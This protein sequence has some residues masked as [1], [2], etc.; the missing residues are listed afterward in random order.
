VAAELGVSRTPVREAPACLRDDRLVEV[1]PQS[2]TFVTR[3]DPQTVSDA[4]VIREA[5]ECAAV[6]RALN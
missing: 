2:R 1:V 5:L 4:Q 6:R 3:V